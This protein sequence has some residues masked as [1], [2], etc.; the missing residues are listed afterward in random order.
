MFVFAGSASSCRKCVR[1]PLLIKLLRVYVSARRECV[2][3]S[4]GFSFPSL[5]KLLCVCVCARREYV[6]LSQE[7]VGS[8]ANEPFRER[9]CLQVVR[10][11]NTTGLISMADSVVSFVL[12]VSA[13]LQ[14]TGVSFRL[15]TIP[16]RT[17]VFD[18]SQCVFPSQDR[19]GH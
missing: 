3:P 18:R 4:Q 9:V 8:F 17:H 1:F 15:L 19:S 5:T 11:S 16:L 7:A 6:F 13:Y 12:T 10:I 2:F 14:H